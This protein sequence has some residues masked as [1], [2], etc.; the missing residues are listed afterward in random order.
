MMYS[1]GAMA[2]KGFM[3]GSM[4]FDVS[5]KEG[6]PPEQ[7]EGPLLPLRVLVMTALVPPDDH[8]SGAGAPE[9]AVRVDPSDPDFLFT[10]LR[11]RASIEIPSVLDGGRPKKIDI[12][13]TSLKSFRPDGLAKDVPLVRSLL[14]GKLV[15]DRL[16]AGE[17]SDD[18]A[19]GQLD[20][21]W[22]GA[23]LAA[24]V[25]GRAAKQSGAASAP[26]APAAPAPAGGGSSGSS[27]LDSI[28]DMVDVPG[29]DGGA[30]DA[31]PAPS[32][33][34]DRL[35][36]IIAEVA[37]GGR[38]AGGRGKSGIPLVE[39]AIGLQIG[40][41]LQHP[42]VR[43]LERAYRG[44]ALLVERS[45]RI[46]G[47]L[48][49]VAQLPADGAAAALRSV[50]RRSSDAPASFAIVDLEIDG[51]ARTLSELEALAAIAEASA[52]PVFVNGTEKLLG[53][54]DLARVD[55]LD[56]K[57]NLFTAPHRA[58]WRATANKPALRWT[59][60]AMNGILGR[61]AY[62]KQTSRVREATVKELPGDHEAEVWIPPVYGVAL[63]A[64]QSFKETG[65][66]A[67]I[68]GARN[69]VIQNLTVR[70]VDDDGAEVALPT[71]AFISTES[72][73]EL[74]RIGIL[75][76]ASAPNSD[77][78]YVH[79]APTAYVQPD[80][81]TYD[82]AS[83]EPENRP[84]A[85]SLVDQLFVARLVQFTRALTSKIPRE[86][87]PSE[88]Q[89]ILKAAIWALFENAPPSGPEIEVAMAK[90]DEGLVAQI[91][92]RPRRFLGVQLEE[93]GFEMPLG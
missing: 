34:D 30:A 14:D 75:A 40:A 16:R 56:S 63:L 82:S 33:G 31:P 37:L 41:I 36:K 23:P 84:P 43:R 78:A 54:G 1:P 90:D 44:L 58:P 19:F 72:Q 71:Q 88:V 13:F 42:V 85:I 39:E 69:G 9:G 21:L 81:K 47:L 48:L 53:V 15:L 22:G 73:R 64:I 62:D 7:T 32:G 12:A 93:F 26:S 67:R 25:L 89:P 77:A 59:A 17:L 74:S 83:T 11:P 86:S 29:G 52:C 45:Q 28:L 51:T 87:D 5:D 49:D 68:T 8:N 2:E 61:L 38:R 80:K 35:G 20:R 70:T 55:K 91:N 4:N 46:P 60:I 18:Q 50:L 57:M 24:E 3:G 6:S 27:A 10:K 66:P 65:W 79:A 76:L 92:V